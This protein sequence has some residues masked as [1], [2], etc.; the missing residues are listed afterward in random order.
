MKKNKDRYRPLFCESAYYLEHQQTFALWKNLF[1]NLN[2]VEKVQAWIV[3]LTLLRRP[4]DWFG[5]KR[6]LAFARP[7][8]HRL[9]LAELV[10]NTPIQIP[11]KIDSNLDLIYF[12][13]ET[14]IKPLPDSCLKALCLISDFTYP[15]KVI[16]EIPEPE[17]LL[18]YQLQSERI[19]SFNES[20]EK[21][22]HEIYGGRDFLSFMI[23]DL[24]HADHFFSNNNHRDGQLGFY[25]CIQK[26]LTDPS[27]T[28]LLQNKDFKAGFEY[29]IS[30]MNSHPVHLFKTLQARVKQT[31]NHDESTS[32]IWKT[33]TSVWVNEGQ[34]VFSALQKINTQLFSDT[35][36]LAI[37]SF[38]IATG[39]N[40][41]L[42][43]SSP[44]L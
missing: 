9:S 42:A 25:R 32:F 23:H 8:R 29:I 27:L 17:K 19:I 33:W 26:I 6:A 18:S 36:A 14:K 34:F 7:L 15:V 16:Y 22:P 21:W 37:E 41:K 44:L 24:I 31:L 5:G 1:K 20:F 12:L 4:N 43:E 38:S 28:R 3:G 11:P 13:S 40:K 35:D 2:P 10:Q 30:D 39:H